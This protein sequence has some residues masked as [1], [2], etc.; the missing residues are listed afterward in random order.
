MMEPLKSMLKLPG[1]TK[2]KLKEIEI[3][4]EEVFNVLKT[5]ETHKASGQGK[6]IPH[7]HA[8]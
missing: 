1:K 5:M 3:T 4:E 8:D 6:I 2:F 7:I